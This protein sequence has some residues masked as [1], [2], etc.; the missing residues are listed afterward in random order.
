MGLDLVV[1]IMEVEEHFGLNIPDN[2][3]Y[4]LTTPRKLIDY[5]TLKVQLVKIGN[6]K[7]NTQAAFYE[8]RKT[9]VTKFNINRNIINPKLKIEE[10]LPVENK[11]VFIK[12]LL[13]SLEIPPGPQLVHEPIF[14]RL[15]IYPFA[16]VF[17]ASTVIVSVYFPMPLTYAIAIFLS[18]IPVQI[19]FHKTPHKRT[20]IIPE[21]YTIGDLVRVVI[22]KN[23]FIKKEYEEPK[24]TW[25][26]EEIDQDVRTIIMQVLGIKNV[27]DKANFIDDLGAG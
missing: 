11:H 17:L 5:V 16:L 6:K 4:H 21:G 12:Q 24:L 10:I 19:I 26:R 22:L 8:I 2:D 1:I 18:Y 25:T 13:T 23:K 3:I 15:I 7:C 27:S 9:L 14:E 20:K